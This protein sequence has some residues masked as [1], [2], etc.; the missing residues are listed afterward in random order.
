VFVLL[1]GTGRDITWNFI[2]THWDEIYKKFAGQMLLS[3]YV[4]VA[5]VTLLSSFYFISVDVCV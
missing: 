1:N 3:R 5:A 2:K 4:S